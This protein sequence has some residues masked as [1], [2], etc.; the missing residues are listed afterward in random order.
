MTGAPTWRSASPGSAAYGEAARSQ[1]SL[2]ALQSTVRGRSPV[3]W[4]E[5]WPWSTA[6]FVASTADNASHI[7]II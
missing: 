5:P 3:W 2:G 4:A 6:A 7:G 1:G